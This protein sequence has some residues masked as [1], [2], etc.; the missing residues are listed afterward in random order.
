MI[1]ALA[2]RVDVGAPLERSAFEV[3]PRPTEGDSWSE[4]LYM[5]DLLH[6]AN[7]GWTLREPHARRAEGDSLGAFVRYQ[8]PDAPQLPKAVFLHDSFGI[9][10]RAWLAEHFS[11]LVCRSTNDFDLQ[12]VLREQ[13]KVVIQLYSEHTLITIVPQPTPLEDEGATAAQFA[14]CPEVLWR[15]D[16][17]LAESGLAADSKLALAAGALELARQRPDELLYLPDL[18]Y[19]R[20]R[21]LLLCV[22]VDAP[23]PGPFQ[24]FYQTEDLRSYDRSRALQG[25]LAAGQSK[26]YFV[27]PPMGIAG[28]LALRIGSDAGTYR[29]NGIE[30][31]VASI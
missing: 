16:G 15:F 11:E 9:P 12:E 26:V 27:L 23:A 8:R 13:P 24:V 21:T 7:L 6:Q 20:D 4:R 3:A 30:I 28:R 1:D 18:H 29:L 10:P 2:D 22:D 14:A 31:R 25:R 19:P 17:T 5:R